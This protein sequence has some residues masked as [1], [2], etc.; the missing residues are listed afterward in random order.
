MSAKHHTGVAAHG[1]GFFP[2]SGPGGPARTGRMTVHRPR[3]LR[4]FDAVPSTR[5]ARHG[6]L[7]GYR[8]AMTVSGSQRAGLIPVHVGQPAP[9]QDDPVDAVAAADAPGSGWPPRRQ[10]R[11]PLVGAGVDWRQHGVEPRWL[12]TETSDCAAALNPSIFHGPGADELQR[13]LAGAGSRQEPALVIAT[14]GDAD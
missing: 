2:G 8:D 1:S 10:D 14:I 6:L 9:T 12:G 3:G 13:F 4:A 7:A 11:I 5:G